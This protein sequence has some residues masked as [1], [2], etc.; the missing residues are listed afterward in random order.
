MN[1]SAELSKGH[2]TKIWA[3]EI[4]VMYITLAE[5]LLRYAIKVWLHVLT[6]NV[7]QVLCT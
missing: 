3:H 6:K 5:Y 2:N 7:R 4:V 1:E